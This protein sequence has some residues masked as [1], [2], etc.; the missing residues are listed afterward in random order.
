[1]L[2]NS[3]EFK[4][5]FQNLFQRGT[6]VHPASFHVPLV[7]LAARG[8]LAGV[9]I[10]SHGVL[11]TPGGVLIFVLLWRQKRDAQRKRRRRRPPKQE[12]ARKRAARPKPP[13]RLKPI[14]QNRPVRKH[15]KRPR[16]GARPKRRRLSRPHKN[17]SLRSPVVWASNV[18]GRFKNFP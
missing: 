13:P 15:P 11:P 4:P 18:I 14:P 12:C 3:I 17:P 6:H 9:A 1:M 2:P 7:Q 16:P 8:W 5:V 10:R